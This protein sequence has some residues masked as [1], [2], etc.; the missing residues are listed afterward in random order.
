MSSNIE[1]KMIKSLLFNQHRICERIFVYLHG[2]GEFGSGPMGQFKYPGFATLL[3]D[4]DLK[5][6]QLFV[7]ACCMEGDYWQPEDLKQYFEW[8]KHRYDQ[9]K[10]D[11]I[12]Y[13][14]GGL[15]VFNYL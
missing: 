6:K 8:L 10:I 5:L 1:T 13:G 9:A 2:A 14:R 7:I 12:G 4:G 15:G 11:L 3:R